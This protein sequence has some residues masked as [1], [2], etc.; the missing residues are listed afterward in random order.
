[1]EVRVL[2]QSELEDALILLERNFDYC[3]ILHNVVFDE[4]VFS[5]GSF[6]DGKLVGHI[7]VYESYQ[8]WNQRKIYTLEYVAVEDLYRGRGI[9]RE[10]LLYVQNMALNKKIDELRLTSNPTRVIAR[11]L[12]TS[13]GFTGKDTGIFIKKLKEELQ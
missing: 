4:H 9:G 7:F 8:Y 10:M 5:V 2:K 13:F 11:A 6:V 3:E 1:M 12:Y